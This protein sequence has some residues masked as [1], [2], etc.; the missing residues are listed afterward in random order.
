MS[1][2]PSP[3]IAIISKLPL[4]LDILNIL[5][6]LKIFALTN[7]TFLKLYRKSLYIYIDLKNNAAFQRLY[8]CVEWLYP[9]VVG[10]WTSQNILEINLTPNKTPLCNTKTP[11]PKVKDFLNLIQ[12]MGKDWIY[13]I[14]A[15]NDNN[16][17]IKT[18]EPTNKLSNN[19]H[20]IM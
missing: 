8:K 14:M 15:T 16:I 1:S 6:G 17:R 3:T 10:S 7:F 2:E 18:S 5:K 13:D 19:E 4:N 11:S 9:M 12:I 20:I